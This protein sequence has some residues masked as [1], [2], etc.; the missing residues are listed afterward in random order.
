MPKTGMEPVRRAEAI[1]AALECICEVGIDSVTLEMV[2]R[3]AG[4]SKGIVAYYF[5]TKQQLILECLK[6][7]MTAYQ[8]KSKS[9]IHE[10]MSP[11]EML[12]VI[13]DTS[14]PPLR[15]I[16]DDTII[17]VSAE[18]ENF[19][20]PEKKI[21]NLFFQFI[22]RAS[23]DS[24]IRETM[25]A[26]YTSDGDSIAELLGYIKST[27]IDLR[28]DDVEGAYGLLAMIYGLSLFRVM[29][30]LPKGKEDNSQIAHDLVA[31]W[32]YSDSNEQKV[33]A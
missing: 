16:P 22:S 18:P 27:G 7:F 5:K 12:G 2:A 21:A 20:L 17:A 31:R 1:N 10:D 26:G 29:G 30:Y 14:L 32:F 15:D 33:E 6:A 24:Q 4:F 19:S 25:N 3:K 11:V 23:T 8:L 13:I 9:A 28:V